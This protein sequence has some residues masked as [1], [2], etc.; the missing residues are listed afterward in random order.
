MNKYFFLSSHFYFLC[1]LPSPW[2][3]MIGIYKPPLLPYFFFLFAFLLLLL[4]R[5]CSILFIARTILLLA[6][7][8]FSLY[9]LPCSLP[10]LLYCCLC[11]SFTCKLGVIITKQANFFCC[12]LCSFICQYLRCFLMAILQG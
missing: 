8:Y 4:F 6:W 11:C 12:A 5:S 10:L 9:W 2:M 3:V 7:P 1:P